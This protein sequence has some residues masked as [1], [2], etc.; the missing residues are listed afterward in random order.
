[1]RAIV[2]ILL[3][4]IL[5]F[6]CQLSSSAQKT[7]TTVPFKYK[8]IKLNYDFKNILPRI[9]R[10]YDNHYFVA[11]ERAIFEFNKEGKFLS[12]VNIPTQIKY[13]AGF[14]KSSNN[15]LIYIATYTQLYVITKKGIVKK[16]F[17]TGEYF[18]YLPIY[19]FFSYMVK[20]NYPK[21]DTYFIR[22]IDESLKQRDFQLSHRFDDPINI[23]GQFLNGFRFGDNGD[24]IVSYKLPNFEQS[25][26]LNLTNYFIDLQFTTFI[27]IKRNR[28]FFLSASFGSGDDT[29]KAVNLLSKEILSYKFKFSQPKLRLQK[30][31]LEEVGYTH[32]IGH[33]IELIDDKL[34]VLSNTV[35]GSFI[36]EVEY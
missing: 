22:Q 24:E 5:S 6:F 13:V 15:D 23:S 9:V 31:D 12:S 2:L 4:S 30:Q 10:E 1:M 19:G 33:F 21:K 8:G 3:T 27:G 32:P 36:Y 35:E 28:A 16:V 11:T 26:V 17:H 20:P 14:Y 29:L 18:D 7:T 25:K 34:L